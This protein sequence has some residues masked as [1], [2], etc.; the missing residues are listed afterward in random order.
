M[1]PFGPYER[2]CKHFSILIVPTDIKKSQL[3]FAH[4]F[5]NPRPVFEIELKIIPRKKMIFDTDRKVVAK[6]KTWIL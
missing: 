5:Q 6:Y 1:T 3:F 4:F 2:T